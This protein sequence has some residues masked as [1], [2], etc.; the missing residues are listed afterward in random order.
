LLHGGLVIGYSQANLPE[1]VRTLA[2]PGSLHDPEHRGQQEADQDPD[3]GDHHQEFDERKP[4]PP[5][6]RGAKDGG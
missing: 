2:P 1:V 6:A 4:V 3:D 5:T